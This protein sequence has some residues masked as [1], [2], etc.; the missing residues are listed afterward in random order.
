MSKITQRIYEALPKPQRA[1]IKRKLP[2]QE[3]RAANTLDKLRDKLGL[4]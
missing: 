2:T 1:V 4:K 3:E